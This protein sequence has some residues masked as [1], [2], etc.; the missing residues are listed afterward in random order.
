MRIIQL[1]DSLA[2]GGAE[3]M[4]VNYANALSDKVAFSGL[5]ATR[6][7]GDLKKQLHTGVAYFFLNRKSTIDL[8]ALFKL[9]RYV[10]AHQVSIVHAHTSSFLL[11]V[12]LKCTCPRIKIVWHDHNGNRVLNK[13]SY[14]RVI[15]WF[16]YF[17]NGVF[18]VNSEL[19]SWAK[20]HLKV[21]K[22]RFVSNFAT[23]NK[24]RNKDYKII[25]G[26]WKAYGLSSKSKV[27]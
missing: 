15:K 23:K 24:K 27:S 10:L 12:L 26:R 22:V 5:V 9:R 11:A 17:F 6:K 4:A 7:E 8:T 1:I 2:P 21:S 20:T 3:R 25:W 14:N 19:E 16:S 13:G 18:T